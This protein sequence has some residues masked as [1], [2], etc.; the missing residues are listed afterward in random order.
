[1]FYWFILLQSSLASAYLA[2]TLLP[3]SSTN[4]GCAFPCCTNPVTTS[5]VLCFLPFL[6]LP[7]STTCMFYPSMQ[8]PLFPSWPTFPSSRTHFLFLV[9]ASTSSLC[10]F[11]GSIGP[12]YSHVSHPEPLRK[13]MDIYAKMEILVL[14]PPT[15]ASDQAAWEDQICPEIP[16]T[17][18]A[19]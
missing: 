2:L 11:P 13:K 8:V 19:L 10:S 3:A 15:Q 4:Y 14:K 12:Q 7:F 5:F 18:V 9:C 1:M 16:R 17:Y 6:I